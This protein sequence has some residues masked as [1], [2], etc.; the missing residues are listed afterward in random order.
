[1]KRIT[2][3]GILICL[4]IT[5]SACEKRQNNLTNMAALDM[6]EY[7]SIIWDEK[8][9][10]PYC[11]ISNRDRGE[12]IGIVDGDEDYQVYQYS[13]YPVE[14]WIILFYHSGEMD[15]SMLMKEMNV[16]EIPTGL[17]SEYEWNKNNTYVE[18]TR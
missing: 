12:Q 15:S 7:Q 8:T 9:Y 18:R 6:E 13:S 3:I 2:I 1:M 16:T 11:A 14:E 4:L 5:L 10:V 17:E